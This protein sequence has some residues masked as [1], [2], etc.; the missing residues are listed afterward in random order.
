MRTTDINGKFM[1]RMAH[2]TKLSGPANFSDEIQKKSKTIHHR[3]TEGTEK[4]F[5]LLTAP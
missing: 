4:S 1:V 5:V 2:P 3:G